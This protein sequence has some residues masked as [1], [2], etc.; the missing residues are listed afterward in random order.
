MVTKKPGQILLFKFPQTDLAGGKVRLDLLLKQV[1]SLS[2]LIETSI[3]SD[4]ILVYP[5]NRR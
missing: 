1:N 2:I 5:V 3:K 4:L